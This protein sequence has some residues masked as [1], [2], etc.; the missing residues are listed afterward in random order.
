M[1]QVCDDLHLCG[2]GS[3]TPLK[4][5]ACKKGVAAALKSAETNKSISEIT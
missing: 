5:F 2:N 3:T 1:L 4:C